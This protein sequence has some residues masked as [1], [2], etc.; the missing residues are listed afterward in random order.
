MGLGLGLGLGVG[1]GV[2]PGERGEEAVLQEDVAREAERT[3][4]AQG[5][6]RHARRQLHLGLGLG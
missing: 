4:R 2:G 1:L 3:E 5:V 6:R